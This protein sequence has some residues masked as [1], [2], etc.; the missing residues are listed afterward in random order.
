MRII[1]LCNTLSATYIMTFLQELSSL[2]CDHCEISLLCG[3]FFFLLRNEVD[4]RYLG[5]IPCAERKYRFKCNLKVVFFE[6]LICIR[7]IIACVC[8]F[9]WQCSH[10][11]QTNCAR[12]DV[13]NLV[14]KSWFFPLQN[15][16]VISLHANHLIWP[17]VWEIIYVKSG[18]INTSIF[19]KI[20]NFEKYC[21]ILKSLV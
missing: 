5:C 21:L 14:S 2:V 16:N 20:L 18:T 17:P 4:I 19:E 12:T 7:I 10:R 11:F 8:T 1:I 9:M 15:F 6:K 3:G 13:R